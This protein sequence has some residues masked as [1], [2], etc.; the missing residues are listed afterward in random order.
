VRNR[1]PQVVAQAGT[2]ML[3]GVPSPLSGSALDDGLPNPPAALTYQWS[4]LSGPGDVTFSA[5]ASPN[6]NAT[7]ETEGTYLVRLSVSDSELAGTADTLVVVS[8]PA[9]QP[10]SVTF[11]SPAGGASLPASAAFELRVRA[12]DADGTI[13]RVEFF[14][15]ST[16]LGSQNTSSDEDPSVYVWPLPNG[17][18]AGT[19]VFSAAATDNSG[20][21]V[22]T[23]PV[24]VH[25]I[26]DPGPPSAIISTPAEDTRISAPVEFT[27]IVSSAVLASWSLDCRLK[28][29]DGEPPAAWIPFSTGTSAAGQPGAPAPLGVLDPTLLIN[30]LYEIRLTATDTVG[31]T[32]TEGPMALLVEGNM[33]V[34]A[35][36]I[37]FNDLVESTP[38]LPI[39]LARTYDS[40]DRRAGDFG[41]GW[42]LALGNIRVQKNRHLG[43]AWWQTPQSGDGFQFY[44]VLP[45]N[46]RLVTVVMP[47]GETHRFR[48]GAYVK[49]R[50]GDPDYSSFSVV[51]REGL[52]KFY[53][54]GDTTSTLEPLDASNQLYDRFWLEGTGDQDLYAGEYGDFDFLP[55]NPTRFRLTTADGTV[56]LLDEAL[57]LLEL[58]DRTGNRL[59]IHRRASDGRIE[60]IDSVQNAETGPI[61]RT[62]EINRLP[63]GRVDSIADLAGRT[64]DYLYDPQGRLASFTD[65]ADNTTQ[66]RYEKSDAPAHPFFAYLTKIIDPRGLP[67]L[68]CEYDDDGRL[69]KQID[70]DGNETV[71][72]RGI[73]AF[74]R[75]EKITDRLGHA[76]TFFYDDRGN[77]T[78]KVDALNATTTY[79]Y[80]ADS[81]RVKFEEDHYGNVKAFAYDARGNVT[82]EILGASR[83]ED[84]ATATTGHITRTTYTTFSAP[85][86]L[87]DPDGRVQSF[88]YDPTTQQL[89]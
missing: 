85:L 78:T 81:D 76:T 51:V 63:D 36:S 64:L 45:I 37:A 60:S 38:G 41:P 61:T 24:T 12:I 46:E 42:H 29:A 71:F 4:K 28:T 62:V 50:A 73:A 18:S 3:A 31:R 17:L 15:G 40:R 33:K 49:N 13:S 32:V 11:V 9:S 58:Q 43:N 89:L 69:K 27:G 84:P 21:T 72:D 70:A 39:T 2:P 23:D 44:D 57:G 80:Y 77:V 16:K 68:R 22:A 75:F 48:A 65:R 82:T 6:T 7:F 19:Y 54:V 34:G 66:F 53:P 56:M 67:A 20:V 88:T 87:T 35:F 1:A 79:D 5:A 47:D 59:V 74:G 26:A 86:S 10:P 14:Q 30:G 25:V 8:A 55:Y 83:S 52:C